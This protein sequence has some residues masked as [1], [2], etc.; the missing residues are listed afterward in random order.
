MP[1]HSSHIGQKAAQSLYH[2]FQ[3]AER[4]GRPL[5]VLVTI[6][7][8]S[9]RCCPT[10]AVE[11]F[12]RLRRHHFNKWMRR[13]GVEP[14]GVYAFENTRDDIVFDVVA[15]GA[16]HNV[17][18]HWG[19][20]VPEALAHDFEMAA[21]EWIEAVSGGLQDPATVIKIT[22][23]P[24]RVVRGYL[25]KGCIDAWAQIYGAVAKPQGAIVGGRRSGTTIN[26]GK[27]ARIAW[28]RA[29]GIRRRIPGRP[30]RPQPPAVP[31]GF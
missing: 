7:F 13:R 15:P 19:V 8:A 3:Q 24:M 10:K 29:N 16:P 9:T 20:H 12:S 31:P 26:I 14:T 17:H 23:R 30:H 6:N 2:A 11:A 27:S 1:I 18:V 25:L 22:Y 5:T 28:D 4:I 21:L